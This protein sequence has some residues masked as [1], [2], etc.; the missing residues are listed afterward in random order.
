MNNL[1]VVCF[2]PARGGS[3]GIPNKNIVD[4]NGRPLLWYS[5][6]SCLGTTCDEVWV[7]TDNKDIADKAIEFG[8]LVLRRPGEISTDISS[9]ELALLHFAEN[10]DFDIVVFVQ[11]TSPL[12]ISE[13]IQKGID[14]VINGVCDSAFSVTE[15][16]WVPRWTKDLKPIRWDPK[17]RPRRQDK[18]S[19][20][21][22]N[23]AFYVTSKDSLLQSKNRYS[24][25]LKTVE[26]PLTRSFQIDSYE[27]MKLIKTL[28]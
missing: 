3:K 2:I 14:L 17:N 28:I 7:S 24:G 10:I 25:I 6:K 11:N 12:I 8:A 5:I 1:K 13:D 16:H 9:S 15:E 27:D 19:V 23:G 21:I 20:F 22:E 18:N 4:I 26:I